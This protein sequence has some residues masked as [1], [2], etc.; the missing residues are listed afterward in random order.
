MRGAGAHFLQHRFRVSGFM[1]E[2]LRTGTGIRQQRWR[3]VVAADHH[4]G[5]LRFRL[6]ESA[7]R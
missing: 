5:A 3:I 2:Q 1:H 6:A 7:G 4:C